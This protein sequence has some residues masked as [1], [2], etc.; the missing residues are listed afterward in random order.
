VRIASVLPPRFS[1]TAL[2]GRGGMGEV[3]LCLDRI[4]GHAVAVKL[5]ASPHPQSRALASLMLREAALLRCLAHPSIPAFF[6]EGTGPRGEPWLSMRYVRGEPLGALL[7]RTARSASV[8]LG[9]WSRE[10]AVT[11]VRDLCLALEHVHE[12]G[13]VHGDVKPANVLAGVDGRVH[14]IDFGLAVPYPDASPRGARGGSALV[15]TPGYIAPER[16]GGAAVAHP[17]GDVYALGCVL[18]EALAHAPLH[19][20]ANARI[21]L[22][23]TLAGTERRIRSWARSAGLDARLEAVC[24]RATANDPAER[25]QSAAQ[26]REQLDAWL[27]SAA[28]RA[29][30]SETAA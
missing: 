13:F 26:L 10:R 8:W 14:L 29:R 12:R 3:W 5:G 23:A 17:R 21:A 2:L 7:A 4:R 25:T 6:D 18:F 20:D 1:H 19:E 28:P 24:L 15:G 30:R 9:R 22:K 16:L 11:L 27:S